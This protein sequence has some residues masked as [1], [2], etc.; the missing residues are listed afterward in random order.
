MSPALLHAPP[1]DELLAE[2]G[3]YDAGG[4]Y[5]SVVASNMRQHNHVKRLR[6][7]VQVRAC[8]LAA[9]APGLPRTWP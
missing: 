9:C 7:R 2:Y 8:L 3:A 1:G 4:S 6:L 5:W